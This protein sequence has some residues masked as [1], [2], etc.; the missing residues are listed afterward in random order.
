MRQLH[1]RFARRPESLLQ[2]MRDRVWLY[3]WLAVIGGV[4]A[5][6]I[7]IWAAVSPR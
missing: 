4:F 7:G 3:G 1:D 5:A 2:R 6:V